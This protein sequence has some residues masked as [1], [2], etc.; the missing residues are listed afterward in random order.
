VGERIGLPGKRKTR[1][2]GVAVLNVFDD[3]DW[4]K[5]AAA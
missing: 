2:G 5:D 1:M 3:E 4:A